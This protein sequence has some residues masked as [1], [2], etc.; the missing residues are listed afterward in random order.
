MADRMARLR[1][2]RARRTHVATVLREVN[3]DSSVRQSFELRLHL[4]RF[5][6]TAMHKF[7]FLLY[8][9]ES[10]Q[11]PAA[12]KGFDRGTVKPYYIVSSTEFT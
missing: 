1:I 9:F 3:S 12:R 7:N 5:S 11:H 6:I 2:G 8:C 4:L 10:N